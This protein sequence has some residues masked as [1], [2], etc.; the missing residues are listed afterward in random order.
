MKS[1]TKS[2]LSHDEI[3]NLVKVNFG[4]SCQIG[5]I[6]EL[7]GGMFNSAYMI[8]R[9]KENDK[10]VLKVS[11]APGTQTLTYEKDPMPT[12]VAV[13]RMISEYTQIPTPKILAYDFSKKHI[14]SNYF[15][16]TALDGKPMNEVMRKINKENH[17][18]IKS[19]YASYFAQM[20][21]IKG[22]YFGYFTEDKRYQFGSWREAY[23]HMMKM[24]L[25]DGKRHGVKLPYK[26]IDKILRENTE[27]LDQI[28]HPTLVN[29][30]LWTGNIFVKKIGEKYVIEGIIDFERAFWG[31]PYADFSATFLFGKDI[32][33]EVIFWK[34]Y[35]AKSGI[36][37]D[38]Q[39][40]DIVRMNLYKLYL[41][42]IMTVETYRYD[43]L[44]GFIQKSLSKSFMLKCLKALERD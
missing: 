3:T 13:Y 28:K 29:Y 39:T 31:D 18:N 33:E 10:I 19:E 22:D 42:T 4:E 16:M 24:I 11:I 35:K 17:E 36:I 1:K 14:P 37:K 27:C 34:A 8:E 25:L 44:V 5:S 9:M 23:L 26:R 2:L 30:D 20:H 38:L 15:F 21:Q 40:E 43:F 32:R 12:E 6:T 41:L 7:K